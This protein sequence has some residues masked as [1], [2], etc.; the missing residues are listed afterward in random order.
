MTPT[1]EN[2]DGS[3]YP[4]GLRGDDISIPARILSVAEFYDS[5]VSNRPCRSAMAPEEA[6]RLIR[7]GA[8]ASFDPD[9]ARAF[10]SM[11]QP[12]LPPSDAT[13]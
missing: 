13:H 10:L 11:T 7:E 6:A 4:Y 3:G 5:A 1:Q 8:S 9:V 12:P 2:F